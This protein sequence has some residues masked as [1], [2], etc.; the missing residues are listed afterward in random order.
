MAYAISKINQL[1]HLVRSIP[2]HSK[3]SFNSFCLV[4]T[5]SDCFTC[6]PAHTLS[7]LKKF[8]NLIS[9]LTACHVTT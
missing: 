7:L 5:Q 9:A 3:Y 2:D 8:S 1:G 4:K 6:A